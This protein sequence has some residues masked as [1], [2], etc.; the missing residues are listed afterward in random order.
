MKKIITAALALPLLLAGANIQARENDLDIT[1]GIAK[2]RETSDNLSSKKTEADNAV[3]KI[4]EGYEAK[5]A[6]AAEQADEQKNL[7]QELKSS[8]K[9][10][11]AQMK[12]DFEAQKAANKAEHEAKTAK[13]KADLEAIKKT[14]Q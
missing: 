10:K 9:E 2:L 3:K 8:W 12:A 6:A 1:G 11:K 13:A 7:K 4:K 14:W 5:K